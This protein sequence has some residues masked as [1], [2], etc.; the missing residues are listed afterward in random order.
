[1]KNLL[2]RTDAG[3]SVGAGHAMRCLAL[4][5]A[6][7]SK[8][9]RVV[10]VMAASAPAVK[11]RIV[12]EMDEVVDILADPGSSR[13]AEQTMESYRRSGAKILVADGYKFDALY[14]K[15]LKEA[16]ARLLLVDDYG[17]ADTYSAD[18]VLNQN[19]HATEKLYAKRA[20]YTKLLLGPRYAML[21][22]EFWLRGGFSRD[23]RTPVRNILVTLGGSDP[24]NVTAKV[25][26]AIREAARPEWQVQVLVGAANPHRA[27]LE[28]VCAG[29][30]YIRLENATEDMPEKMAWADLAVTASGSTV[31]ET[32]FMGLPSVVL[33]LA[34]NQRLI[35]ETLHE[36]GVVWNA[37]WAG[38]AKIGEAVLKLAADKDLRESLSR[39][40]RDL[41]DGEGA[42]KIAEEICDGAN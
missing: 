39:A 4:G 23:T 7:R 40:G 5:Q 14:Q 2:I 24:G 17:H 22:K 29:A 34:E 30:P 12:D 38:S 13:D 8:G 1:M 33:I 6:W 20:S 16:G 28:S 18:W 27:A 35:A 15:R 25:I 41:V 19:L 10:F 9:G 42:L 32:A 31:W 21:R 3:E 11:A 26:A 37:G 36:R